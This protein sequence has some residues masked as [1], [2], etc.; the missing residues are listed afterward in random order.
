MAHARTKRRESRKPA[1]TTP[2]PR[3]K[4][5]AKLWPYAL[6]VFIGLFAVMKAYG[7]ALNGPFLFDDVYLPAGRPD[8][9]D[10]PLRAWLA[11]VRPMLMFSYWANFRLSG[12]EPFSYHLWNVFIH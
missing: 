11:G 3:Q 1:G 10:Q 9:V 12:Q 6:A 7:P 2:A 4:P 5:V 8:F